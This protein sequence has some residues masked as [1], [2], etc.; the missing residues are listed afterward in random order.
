VKDSRLSFLLPLLF[1][2]ILNLTAE[3]SDKQVAADSAIFHR[4][5]VSV[6]ERAH[7]LDQPAPQKSAGA[8][9]AYQ[10][11]VKLAHRTS[12]N[13]LYGVVRDLITDTSGEEE[14]Y[15]LAI[16]TLDNYPP[17]ASRRIVRAIMAD[18]KY[19]AC[20]DVHNW[21]WEIDEAERARRDPRHAVDY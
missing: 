5:R 7:K 14:P 3:P 4:F 9:Y 1:G 8:K 16:M 13:F 19:A 17:D 15:F 21:L 6:L 12:P 2:T 11:C 18:P 20:T 10:E